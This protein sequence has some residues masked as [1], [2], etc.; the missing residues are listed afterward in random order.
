[1][2][3]SG[4]WPKCCPGAGTA[5][6]ALAA[7]LGLSPAASR[8]Q[9]ADL[10]RALVYDALTRGPVPIPP[11]ERGLLTVVAVPWFKVSDEALA[12]EGPAF[13]RADNLLFSDASHGQMFRLTPDRQL[14]TVVGPNKLGLGGLAIHRD[15]R[16]LAGTGNMTSGGS[17]VALD[18]D[19]TSLTAIIPSSA[20]YDV[21]DIVF[22]AQGGFYFS[23]LRGRS[24]DPR[25]GVS[26]VAPDLRTITPM[27]PHLAM[28]NGVALSPNGRTL[29]VTAA[30]R[31]HPD[32]RRRGCRLL[33]HRPGA[34]LAAHFQARAFAPALP[35]Y[36]HR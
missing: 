23:D 33:L 29:W 13:D 7:L 1:M 14:T 26:H 25:G 9:P 21:N 30:P 17:I 36:P 34:E 15:G 35:L 28:A 27:L 31:H 11:G 5:W 3:R 6:L 22:D 2:R 12:L 10:T 20:G 4:S 32:R 19:G 8:S 16:I 24:T 18:P